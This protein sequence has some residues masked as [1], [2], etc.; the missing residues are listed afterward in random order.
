M[1]RPVLVLLI[2]VFVSTISFAQQQTDAN[3]FVLRLFARN[4]AKYRKARRNLYAILN[5]QPQFWTELQ[6]ASARLS[7]HP[8][9]I[10]NVMATESLF[11]ADARNPLP[12]Q[13]ASGLLQIID[14]TAKSMGTTAAAIR[15]MSPIQQLRYVERYLEPFRGQLHSLADVYTAVFR[16][17]IIKGGDNIIIVDF[18]KE[19]RIY[20]LNSSLDLNQD[21]RITKG[22]L[23]LAA[24]SVGRF[25]PANEKV[26]Q[27]KSLSPP[28]RTRS[29]F[30]RR[31]AYV[32]P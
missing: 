30:I 20:T 9:W 24:L 2:I 1:R 3:D 8:A 25:V 12:G 19:P 14:S 32:V 28:T 27:A 15:K 26:Q 10:L 21:K 6:A 22:E 4:T 13:T 31:P 29:I 5:E 11:D 7:T 23:A 17:Q 16:G 18:K